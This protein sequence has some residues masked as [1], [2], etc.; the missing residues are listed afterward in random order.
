RSAA[1]LRQ[2]A[3]LRED[4]PRARSEADEL[5]LRDP[6]EHDA[7]AAPRSADGRLPTHSGATGRRRRLLRQPA[8]RAGGR[9]PPARAD[10]L[11]GRLGG[12]AP[13]ERVLERPPLLPRHGARRVLG[14]GA[15]GA[16]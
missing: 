3:L 10:A 5:A 6:A 2:L 11:S 15:G 7:E 8:D 9:A 13:R 14:H 12:S 4:P 16:A 1:S